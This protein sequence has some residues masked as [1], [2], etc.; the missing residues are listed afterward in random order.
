[1]LLIL[2]LQLNSADNSQTVQ[3]RDSEQPACLVWQICLEGIKGAAAP[4]ICQFCPLNL[5]DFFCKDMQEDFF[6]EQGLS[7]DY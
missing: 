5:F 7:Q 1:M 2:G 3:D 4:N 6:H